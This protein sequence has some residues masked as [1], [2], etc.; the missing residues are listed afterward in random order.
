MHNNT[1][2]EWC[3]QRASGHHEF[4]KGL[5]I[6]L[7]VTSPNDDQFSILLHRRC[8]HQIFNKVISEDLSTP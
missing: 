4:Q 8:H 5:T 1:K 7:H 2:L 3:R 6:L